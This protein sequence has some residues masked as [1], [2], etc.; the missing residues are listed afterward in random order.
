MNFRILFITSIISPFWVEFAEEASR[1]QHLQFVVAFTTSVLQDRGSHWHS[2]SL[3]LTNH[4]SRK[5]EPLDAWLS[6]VFADYQPSIVIIGGARSVF[7][8]IAFRLGRQYS[9]RV[10]I[11][12]EQPNPKGPFLRMVSFFAYQRELRSMN[13]DFFLAVG[14][15]AADFYRQLLPKTC[16][17]VLF[18]Y[19]QKLVWGCGKATDLKNTSFL[20]S[21]RLLPR[22]S[23]YEMVQA[24]D[25]LA[26]ERPG[27]F[28]WCISAHGPE[29]YLVREAMNNSPLLA[30]SI[31]FDRDFHEWND[32]LKPFFKADVLV[33]PAKHSGWG[34][35]VPEALAL[36][37]PIITTRYMESARYY[38]EGMVN[39]IFVEPNPNEIYKALIYCV[40]HP[41]FVEKMKTATI[42]AA[43]KGDVSMGVQR[44][45]SYLTHWY[46]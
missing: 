33:V 2:N 44:L 16:P 30:R 45:I 1:S 35:V 32:R 24:F 20:F 18:P 43:S 46:G 3:D 42:A 15:R 5:E 25:R 7:S 17:V 12:A 29:E 9:A 10:G 37:L 26:R 13:P 23:I 8:R 21:G 27:H 36:G 31:Y 14:D 38:V 22:N 19:Y 39:G 6:T 40:D 41:S 11:F 4:Y 28:K 34:L